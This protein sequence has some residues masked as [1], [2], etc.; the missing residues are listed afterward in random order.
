VLVLISAAAASFGGTSPLAWYLGLWA[1]RAPV[2]Q[3]GPRLGVPR[4]MPWLV[5]GVSVLAVFV[6]VLGPGVALGPGR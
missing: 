6:G 1:R 3:A 5:L 2:G 4:S